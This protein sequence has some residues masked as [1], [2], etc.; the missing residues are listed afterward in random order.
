M[1]RGVPPTAPEART[2]ESTPPGISERARWKS[3]SERVM[4]QPA[5]R[6]AQWLQ[7][8]ISLEAE[9]VAFGIGHHDPELLALLEDAK[10]ASTQ[11]L[12]PDRLFFDLRTPI[13][14]GQAIPD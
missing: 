12:D 4:R 10:L 3:S 6:G 14:T 13:I 2:G 1:K 9:L 8:P 7:R 5:R 11:R